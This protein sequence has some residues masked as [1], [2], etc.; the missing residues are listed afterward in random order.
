MKLISVNCE[1]NFDKIYNFC[2]NAESDDSPAA[3][4]MVVDRWETNPASLLNLIYI[5]KR[6][7][8]SNRADYFFL[9]H[10]NEYIAGSGFYQLDCDLNICILGVRTYTLSNYRSQLVHG[11]V[12]LPMQKEIA[13]TSGYKSLILTFNDYNLWLLKSIEKL[14]SGKGKIIGNQI[15]IF[16]KGWSTL[17]FKIYVKYTEQ[18]CMY[19][20]I[21]SSYESEFFK[22]VNSIRVV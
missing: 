7:D 17:D 11:N 10:D 16:Y 22:S 12:I 3:S 20:H 9:E 13:E 5:Q 6:F 19:Q 4:N 15:P 8:R 18:S 21:D 1:L 2:K 14:S